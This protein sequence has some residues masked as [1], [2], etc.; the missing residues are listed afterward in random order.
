MKG[1]CWRSFLFVG[2]KEGERCQ[3]LNLLAL[4][5]LVSKCSDR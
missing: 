4:K 5:N 2:E 3:K 1:G